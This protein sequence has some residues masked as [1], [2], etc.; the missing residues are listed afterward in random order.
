MNR[1]PSHESVS[2]LSRKA[3]IAIAVSLA[4]TLATG[5]ACAQV[6]VTNPS[7][8]ANNHADFA[9]QLSKTIEQYTKQ[10]QQYTLQIQQ[11]QQ[12]LITIQNLGNNITINNAPQHLDQGQLARME[13]GN[14]GGGA[15]GILGSFFGSLLAPEGP[16]V[17]KQ[18]DICQQIVAIKVKKYN[19][20]SDMMSRMNYYANLANKTE[21][22]R[23]SVGS[24]N[25]GNLSANSNQ[26]LRNSSEL[27][28]EMANWQTQ[29]QSYDAML[30]ALEGAQSD[31]AKAALN[32]NPSLLNTSAQAAVLEAALKVNQ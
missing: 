10:V 25:N 4:C 11:Y 24:S 3:C 16:Y 7:L 5:S 6:I 13:C 30:K 21:D 15:S 23:N 17:Q 8:Q 18:Q 9:S 32:G 19:D 26:V 1:I 14:E 28:A 12:M 27:N 31:L 2:C 29:M 22:S 20:T